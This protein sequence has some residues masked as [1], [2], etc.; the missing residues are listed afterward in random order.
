MIQWN[1][2]MLAINEGI[3]NFYFNTKDSTFLFVNDNWV[4]LV[5]YELEKKLI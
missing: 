2:L 5:Q 4:L 3:K 1:Y